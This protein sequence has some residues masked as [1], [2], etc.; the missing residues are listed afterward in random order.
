MNLTR[1]YCRERLE[2]IAAIVRDGC[3]ADGQAERLIVNVVVAFD[4]AGD[5][6]GIGALGERNLQAQHRKIYGR[7]SHAPGTTDA[8]IS[9]EVIREED[10]ANIGVADEA[11]LSSCVTEDASISAVNPIGAQL[12]VMGGL[13]PLPTGLSRSCTICT[14]GFV[15]CEVTLSIC[16]IEDEYFL[17]QSFAV[18]C[19]RM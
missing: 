6:E 1:S 15:K 7:N 10:V 8:I 9:F 4:D 3:Y 19:V 17:V 2:M 14:A 11:A 5:H 13:N 12:H 18:V 16:N